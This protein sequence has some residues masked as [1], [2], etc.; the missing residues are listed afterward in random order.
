VTEF[1]NGS[2]DFLL[3]DRLVRCGYCE[4]GQDFEDESQNSSL[5]SLGVRIFETYRIVAAERRAFGTTSRPS[6]NHVES[7]LT[8][9]AD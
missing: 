4:Q 5:D 8:D 1:L 3:S 9:F 2:C 6:Q 7:D